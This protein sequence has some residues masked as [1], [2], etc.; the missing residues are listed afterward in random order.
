MIIV[1]TSALVAILKGERDGAQCLAV[2]Q[3]SQSVAISAVTL[4]EALIVASH[5]DFAEAMTGLLEDLAPEVVGVTAEA[6]RAVAAAHKRWGRGAHPAVLN[7][8]DCFSYQLATARDSAL[9]FVGQDFGRTD[10]I[11]ALTEE[12]YGG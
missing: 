11:S 2:L 4:A 6:A 10:V 1:D 5:G 9:L 8:A 12:A 3:E 7:F